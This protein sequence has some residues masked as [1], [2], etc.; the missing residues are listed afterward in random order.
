MIINFSLKVFFANCSS[1]H[2]ECRLDNR[3]NAFD[4]RPKIVRSMS[5][6]DEKYLIFSKLTVSPQNVPLDT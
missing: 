5:E 6:N 1:G 2:G 3:A 4:K